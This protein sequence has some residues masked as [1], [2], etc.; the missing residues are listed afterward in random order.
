MKYS[1][2]T[3]DG[4]VIGPTT[5]TDKK[6]LRTDI[7]GANTSSA[8]AIK[9]G[10]TFDTGL[11][12]TVDNLVA[13][14][15]TN[16]GD[17]I[18]YNLKPYD[19]AGLTINLDTCTMTCADSVQDP[20]INIYPRLNCYGYI[21]G[22]AGLAISGDFILN[23]TITTP[24]IIVPIDL[25][26]KPSGDVRIF[27]GKTLFCDTISQN[28]NTSN[29]AITAVGSNKNINLAASG[30]G[31]INLNSPAVGSTITANTFTSPAST[32]LNINAPGG[33]IFLNTV[34]LSATGALGINSGGTM[35]L[36]PTNLTCIIQAYL[37]VARSVTAT[38]FIGDELSNST[39]NGNIALIPNGTGQIQVAA[40]K[41][42]TADIISS[43]TA[44]GN[45]T[46]SPNGTGKVYVNG[47]LN[48]DQINPNVGSSNL[49]IS[50]AG[51]S[52]SIFLNAS[53]TGQ[54]IS[55]KAFITSVIGS[56]SGFDIVMAP[57]TG[58]LYV[59]GTVLT[60]SILNEA[61]NGS[62]A[63]SA[64]GTGTIN[65]NSTAV[66]SIITTTT[67]GNLSL[68]PNGTG[69]VQITS[70]KT[71][72]T[73]TIKS[74]G[75]TAIAVKTNTTFD[76][77]LTLTV[78]NIISKSITNNGNITSSKLLP[79]DAAGL[80]INLDTCTMT[81]A[82]S[83]ANPQI[84]INPQL[85]VNGTLA[86]TAGMS[87]SGGDLIVWSKITTPY[88][89]ST[90]DLQLNPTG[91]VRV[92]GNKT[93]FCNAISQNDT[94]TDLYRTAGGTNQNVVISPAGT[95]QVKVLT[96]KTLSADNIVSKTIT[97][98]GTTS[99]S[100][101]LTVGSMVPYDFAGLNINLNTCTMTCT[102]AVANPQIIMS[103]PVLANILT[104]KTIRSTDATNLTINSPGCTINTNATNII[105]SGGLSL[106]SNGTLNLQAFTGNSSV[107]I[108]ASSSGVVSMLSPLLVNTIIPYNSAD[109]TL[110]SSGIN[111]NIALTATG[112]GTIKC[113]SPLTANTITSPAA[114]NLAI[115]APGGTISTNATNI[116]ASGVLALNSNN[117]RLSLN[118]GT[119]IVYVSS[120][121]TFSNS[122]ACSSF[123]NGV[124]NNIVMT[125]LTGT[126]TLSTNNANN[127]F[128]T[129]GNI[130][131]FG[132]N[133][134]QLPNG[135]SNLNWY[136][137]YQMTGNW[138]INSATFSCGYCFIRI[139][140]MVSIFGENVMASIPSAINFSQNYSTTIPS[141]FRPSNAVIANFTT[142]QLTIQ[143]GGSFELKIVA[144]GALSVR[145]AQTI[146][147]SLL[148][149]SGG[150]NTNTIVV[151][152]ASGAGG[153]SG[154]SDIT[155]GGAAPGSGD[156]GAKLP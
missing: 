139:G 10:M 61:V 117:S 11:T 109:L 30:T 9:S 56:S 8:I 108:S 93:L 125:P 106:A 116:T 20:R 107:N 89:G 3:P 62:L 140:K 16:N 104:V 95:G 80:Q 35:T 151:G 22:S 63:L 49:S 4:L 21:T 147:Y 136:E 51:A 42:F 152:G 92:I 39:T 110:A 77:S 58:K 28:T 67:N 74:N 130:T 55:N 88:V 70:G 17:V 98:N 48:V 150:F 83:I 50:A 54:I 15:V 97:V 5:G 65:L 91:N 26:L 68:S 101:V 75:A 145:F 24:T 156:G 100:G 123:S 127:I 79:Y 133:G 128:I 126:I 34:N 41:T 84:I 2:G 40:G 36:W 19:L 142:H 105:A 59:N 18:A 113:N 87:L 111:G 99:I 143:P 73:D 124:N 66:A 13:K 118:A 132:G 25:T 94:N 33:T 141:Q 78:D 144:T 31:I 90:T 37:T 103:S 53:G 27:T 38:K 122:I 86:C 47:S 138:Y 148:T 134:I 60:S 137:E 119:S 76:A 112:N 72:A 57:N 64:N 23:S 46:I 121:A 71:L 131:S 102:D 44:N 149:Y 129:P 45:I 96:G 69:Q 12:L 115:N 85:Q 29:L 14:S 153:A 52:G 135:G 81:C 7:I 154:S 146:T 32:N 120:P 1:P 155:G 114:T 43:T 6:I 82:D